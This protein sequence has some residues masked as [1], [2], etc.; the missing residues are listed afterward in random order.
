CSW[1]SSSLGQGGCRK[2]PARSGGLWPNS[3][4][5]ATVSKARFMTKSAIWSS[6]KR[7]PASTSNRRSV[8]ATRFWMKHTTS[9]LSGFGTVSPNATGTTCRRSTRF[10]IGVEPAEPKNQR[11]LGWMSLLRHREE[12]RRRIIYSLV[13]VAAC[14]GAAWWWVRDIYARVAKPVTVVL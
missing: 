10:E 8:K 13:A 1:P 3:A 12:L 5:P 14:R 2:S 4:K 6:K 7:I 9:L 11:E